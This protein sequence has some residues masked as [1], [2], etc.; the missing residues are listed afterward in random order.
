MMN[1]AAIALCL[2]LFASVAGGATV[3]ILTEGWTGS[4]ARKKWS[5]RELDATSP[6][7]AAR[8]KSDSRINSPIWPEAIVLSAAVLLACSTNAPTRWLQI[9]FLYEDKKPIRPVK[10]DA[11]TVADSPE[12]QMIYA[13]QTRSARGIELTL[14]DGDIG[15]W[16]V[17]KI[18]L[19]CSGSLAGSRTNP[20]QGFALI[21]Q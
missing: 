19:A 17:S 12:T 2:A 15:E 21:I 5:F 14:S 8:F 18:S 16:R 4:G 3:E 11:I 13:D 9:K 7:N 20:P 6:G 1:S 10:F